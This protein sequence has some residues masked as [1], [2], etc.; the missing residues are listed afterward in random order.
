MLFT[1]PLAG[2]CGDYFTRKKM[3]IITSA[4]TVLLVLPCFYLLQLKSIFFVLLSLSIATI[5]SSADQ[6]NSLTAIVENCP[7]NV[8]YSGVA[9]FFQ[10]R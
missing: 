1:V 2:L 8:R 9:F 5:P 6:G 7:E 10:P 4:A 3:L